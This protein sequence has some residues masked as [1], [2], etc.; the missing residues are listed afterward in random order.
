MTRQYRP[1]RKA[2]TLRTRSVCRKASFKRPYGKLRASART[3]ARPVALSALQF[4]L[5]SRLSSFNSRS[6][7]TSQNSRG[8]G[9]SSAKSLILLRLV[10]PPWLPSRTPSRL[11]QAGGLSHE[12]ARFKEPR[13]ASVHALQC[14]HVARYRPTSGSRVIGA[15]PREATAPLRGNA[16]R[17][18]GQLRADIARWHDSA[19]GQALAASQV[20]FREHGYSCRNAS[21]GSSRE[22]RRA[23]IIQASRA[24]TVSPSTTA[25]SATGSVLGA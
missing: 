23:G 18:T 15:M 7:A 24:T 11:R 14:Q 5:C 9:F 6:V 12:K 8:F 2:S 3:L 13:I 25:P 22:A 16:S 1:Y 17:Q 21:I 4:H 10:G 19:L 20:G